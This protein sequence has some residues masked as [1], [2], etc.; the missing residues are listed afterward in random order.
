M[1]NIIFDLD[2][3][4]WDTT[5]A[6]TTAWNKTIKKF[7][8]AKKFERQE[9]VS[10]MGKTSS[11]LMTYL[12]N[13]RQIEDENFLKSCQNQEIEVLKQSGGRLYPKTLQTLKYLSVKKHNLYIIS[14]CQENYIDIFLDFHNCRHLFCGY[15]CAD[16]RFKNKE[17]CLSE[18]IKIQKINKFFYVGDSESDHIAC[19]NLGGSFIFANYGFGIS[20]SFDFFIQNITD[21]KSLF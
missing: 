7:N 12:Q 16:S 18:L 20:K 11:E 2:G 19:K 6:V 1:E 10:L 21:L 4:L 5:E 15:D 17:D 3:T 14:N 9:I 8:L 13:S